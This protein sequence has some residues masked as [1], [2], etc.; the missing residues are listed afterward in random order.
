MLERPG[1]LSG[2]GGFLN[3][4]RIVGLQVRNALLQLND[5]EQKQENQDADDVVHFPTP[6]PESSQSLSGIFFVSTSLSI[7]NNDA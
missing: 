2:D 3:M 1:C 4:G 5:F 6:P 7:P